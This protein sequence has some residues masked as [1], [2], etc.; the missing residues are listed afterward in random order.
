MS[1]CHFQGYLCSFEILDTIE[2]ICV[3]MHPKCTWP[4][5]VKYIRR[6]YIN[7]SLLW[8]CF[9]ITFFHV[10]YIQNLNETAC[11]Q[12]WIMFLSYIVS[13]FAHDSLA[14]T[15]NRSWLPTLFWTQTFLSFE[16]TNIFFFL[17]I[18][19]AFLS[20]PLENEFLVRKLLVPLGK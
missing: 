11:F 18:F 13:S 5:Q 16:E 1:G 2:L 7:L 19:C 3:L 4:C 6:N 14:R 12:V 20:F 10:Q 17:Y 9:E 15:E 8:Y